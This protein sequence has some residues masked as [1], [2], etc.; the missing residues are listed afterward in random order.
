MQDAS[1]QLGRA[2]IGIG[3]ALIVAG[4]LFIYAKQLRLGSLPGDITLSGRSW[5][6]SLWLGTSLLLSIVF[7]LAL[8]LLLRRR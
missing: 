2:L 5:Q 1:G 4:V 7:T 6:V 8:N 3:S